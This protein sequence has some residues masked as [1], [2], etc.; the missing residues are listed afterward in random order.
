MMYSLWDFQRVEKYCRSV[1]ESIVLGRSALGLSLYYNTCN[2]TTLTKLF[3]F[4]KPLFSVFVFFSCKF[5]NVFKKSCLLLS[6][7]IENKLEESRNALT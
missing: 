7:V 3:K 6:V 2:F 4:S 5:R 1:V